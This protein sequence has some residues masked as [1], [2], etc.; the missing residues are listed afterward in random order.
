M[1]ILNNDSDSDDHRQDHKLIQQISE[2]SS[3][4]SFESP[5]N[6]KAELVTRQ[7]SS[8]QFPAASS[9]DPFANPK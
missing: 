7:N 4:T 6:I 5:V 1:D 2:T 3:A 9:E 8:G